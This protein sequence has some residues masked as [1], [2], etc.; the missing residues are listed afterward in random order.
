MKQ[1]FSI[2]NLPGSNTIIAFIR[3]IVGL[4]MLYH[5]FEVFDAAKLK[6]YAEWDQFKGFSH[7]LLMAYLGKGSEFIGGLL[8]ALGLLTRIGCL[9]IICT[10]TYITFFIGKG[11][12]WM[13]DQHPF[14]FVLLALMIFFTGP[15]KG[16]ADEFLFKSNKNK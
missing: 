15:G 7:P 1:F 9:I 6:E 12:I 8:L 4:F 3:I 11:Q 10:L 2:S 13:D 14:L 16:S 5:G